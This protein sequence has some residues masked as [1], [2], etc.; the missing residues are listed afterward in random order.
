LNKNRKGFTLIEVVISMVVIAIIMYSVIAVFITAGVRG[1]NVEVFTV[2]QS[3]AEGKME[4][5]MALP[6]DSIQQINA[7]P[8]LGDLNAYHYQVEVDYVD[9]NNFEEPS[10][11]PQTDYRRIIVTI[12]HPKLEE[13]G[14]TLQSVRAN[15]Q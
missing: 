13:N 7:T 5:V 9:A 14:I 1:V 3:L 8:F 10:L 6:F 2:A 11:Q 12:T 15:Y 4:E